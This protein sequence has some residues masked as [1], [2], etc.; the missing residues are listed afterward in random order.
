MSKFVNKNPLMRCSALE[1]MS[2]VTKLVNLIIS[3]L[4]SKINRRNDIFSQDILRFATVN[5]GQAS[6][7]LEG[8]ATYV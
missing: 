2:L 5:G 3:N 8:G 1:G 6:Y 7:I 4:Y